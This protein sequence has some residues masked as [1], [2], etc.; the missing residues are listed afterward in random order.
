MY[1]H[2]ER[3]KSDLSCFSWI[4]TILDSII[5]LASLEIA[6]NHGDTDVH[7]NNKESQWMETTD[8]YNAHQGKSI[9]ILI[10]FFLFYVT[11]QDTRTETLINLFNLD[12][13]I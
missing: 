3:D 1:A 2:L 7:E 10:L 12:Q 13:F 11:D 6:V 4:P 9:E 5:N 8:A